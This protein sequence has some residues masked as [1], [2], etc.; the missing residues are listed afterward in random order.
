MEYIFLYNLK[1]FAVFDDAHQENAINGIT[2]GIFGASGQS[3]IAGS[4]LYLKK[5]NNNEFLEKYA[6]AIENND[7]SQVLSYTGL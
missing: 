3:C 4:R 7:L 6:L 1:S 2:A 5:G